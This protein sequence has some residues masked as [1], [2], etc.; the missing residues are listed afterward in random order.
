MVLLVVHLLSTHRAAA[1]GFFHVASAAAIAFSFVYAYVSRHPKPRSA[2]RSIA[3]ALSYVLLA[4]LF[5]FVIGTFFVVPF[6]GYI[7]RLK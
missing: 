4:G 7:Q 3:I 6:N 2:G 5:Y 1:A